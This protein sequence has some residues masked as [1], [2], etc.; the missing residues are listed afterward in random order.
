M[1]K[2][3]GAMIT[4][5]GRELEAARKLAFSI[6]V[7]DPQITGTKLV[8]LL[9]ER[10][11]E[12]N[13]Y[14]VS[15]WIARWR[16]GKGY[17]QS[18]RP[19]LIAEMKPIRK[20]AFSI[21]VEDPQITG[22]KLAA[23]LK[24]RGPEVSLS[25]YYRW[26][27]SWKK[28]KGYAQS[29]RAKLI[30]EMEPARMLAFSIWSE[31]PQITGT[32]LVALLKE[33]G[34]EVN[35]NT[36]NSWVDRWRK[37]KG[38]DKSEKS[39]LIAK[40]EPIRK[41]AFSIWSEDPQI[42][43]TKLVALLK[44]RGHEVKKSTCYYWLSSWKKDKGHAPREKSKL[45][46]ILE[47]SRMFAFSI[48]SEDPQITG[49]KLVAL[50]KERGYEVSVST[51]YSWVAR[52][53]KG[54]GYARSEKSKLIAEMEPIRK[55]AFSI[56]IRDPQIKGSK[57]EA[58]LK[59]SGHE[60]GVNTCY[61]W[62]SSWGKGKGYAQSERG[63]FEAQVAAKV[64]A[65]LEA[66]VGAQLEAEVAPEVAEKIEPE[67]EPEKKAA[68]TWEQI[69][70]AAPDIETL[71]VLFFQGVMMK[72]GEKD[73]A[74]EVLRQENLNQQQAIA[75]RKRDLVTVTGERNRIMRLYN[76]LLAKKNIGTLTLDQVNHRLVAKRY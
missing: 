59:E 60:V 1:V 70:R 23:L 6:C 72:M 3:K 73:D 25:T 74:Y 45:E 63:K 64:A 69:V 36:A 18:E 65:Q 68:L 11:H 76:E 32:K 47:P 62:L 51:C 2:A 28:D 21:W 58:L 29:E 52:W 41:L 19:K 61:Y 57:L 67:I 39:K 16:K 37:G 14:T 5:R 13:R 31:D 48:W 9:K 12:V 42:T 44:E 46:A 53:G 75:D 26:L 22:A 35:Q 71:S 43:G 55:I 8:A 49:S 7:Q 4:S 33:R 17:A 40:L 10:G 38:P 50:L 66:K 20:L 56:W 27:A 15:T 54:R 34:H 30:A 24:E